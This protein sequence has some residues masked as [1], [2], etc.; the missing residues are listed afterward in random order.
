MRCPP[1]QFTP[2][3]YSN[4]SAA[5]LQQWDIMY[6][7]EPWLPNCIKTM[8]RRFWRVI[9]YEKVQPRVCDVAIL[10]NTCFFTILLWNTRPSARLGTAE[11]KGSKS[12]E[13]RWLI[14]PLAC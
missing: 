2:P 4:V 9:P 6:K 7:V 14:L 12:R 13:S 3:P 8:H 11:Q 5:C 10:A 1:S